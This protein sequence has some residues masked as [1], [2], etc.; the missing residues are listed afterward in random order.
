M[1]RSFK[2]QRCEG[3]PAEHCCVP[4]CTTSAKF[5]LAVTFHTFPSDDQQR[6]KWIINTRR[7]NLAISHHTRVCSQRF[8]SEEVTEPTE[9]G[10]RRRLKPDA[11]P[12]LFPWNS[13]SLGMRKL[14]VWERRERP[15]SVE[16]AGP[17][18][19]NDN[20]YCTS[21]DPACVDLVLSEN[22]SLRDK[23]VQLRQQ[24]E[25]LSL[26]Q[27]FGLQRFAGSD[28]DIR[29][30]TRCVSSSDGLAIGQY[31][32]QCIFFSHQHYDHIY[33][34]SLCNVWPLS[35]KNVCYILLL[36]H[37]FID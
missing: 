19:A 29:F 7:Y 15:E 36:L 35:V 6:K 20:D 34:Y 28:R 27:C 21:P 31:G 17:I 30:Y 33:I 13:Y 9:V 14:G 18:C 25:Q 32:D 24:L 1:K 3:T 8:V 23:I 26:K 37:G 12:V 5:N 16:T 2:F 4:L 10:G 11:I 22:E